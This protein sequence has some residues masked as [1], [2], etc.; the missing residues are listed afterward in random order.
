MNSVADDLE[1]T[2]A[3][4]CLKLAAEGKYRKE[5]A[6]ILKI[7]PSTVNTYF[8]RLYARLDAHNPAQAYKRFLELR[9][10]RLKLP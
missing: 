6:Q 8:D 1:E 7:H 5:I 3:I 2:R 9:H 10:P 4:E